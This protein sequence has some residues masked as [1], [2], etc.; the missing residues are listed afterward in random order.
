MNYFAIFVFACFA[1]ASL[2]QTDCPNI[3][4]VASL[5][6]TRYLGTWYEI[7]KF[8]TY[9]QPATQKCVRATYTPINSVTVGVNNTAYDYATDKYEFQAGSATIPDPTV[10]GKLIV[11]FQIGIITTRV[12]YWVIDTNYNY[13]LVYSCDKLVGVKIESAWILSRNPTLDSATI[14]KLS[15]ILQQYGV[16]TSKFAITDQSN[17]IY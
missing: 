2:A 10:P 9:F 5:N 15:N 16:D 6:V 8:P 11:T 17:C 13:S 14:N 4:T 7:Q 12:N 1:G 3:P